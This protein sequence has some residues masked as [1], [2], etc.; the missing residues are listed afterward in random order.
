MF[1]VDLDWQFPNYFHAQC[2]GHCG[3]NGQALAKT[4]VRVCLLNSALW[5]RVTEEIFVPHFPLSGQGLSK[6]IPLT[7]LS[8][9]PSEIFYIKFLSQWLRVGGMLVINTITKNSAGARCWSLLQTRQS[10]FGKSKGWFQ[11]TQWNTDL[12]TRNSRALFAVL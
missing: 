11:V 9:G 7:G 8:S 3:K 5:P 4:W 10:R 6:I 1:A 12:K 2:L